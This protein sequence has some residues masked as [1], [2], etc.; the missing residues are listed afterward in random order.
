MA[1]IHN[2]ANNQGTDGIYAVYEKDG[3]TF[4]L[5]DNSPESV[6]QGGARALSDRAYEQRGN[7][8]SLRKR[9]DQMIEEAIKLEAEAQLI[10]QA[11]RKLHH[12]NL[13]V[14]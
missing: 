7:A 3:K 4:D 12:D 14:G 8:A 2:A 11:M 5:P 10:Y 13:N 1:D 9:A 6:L